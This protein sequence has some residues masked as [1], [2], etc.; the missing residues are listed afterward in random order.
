MIRN[1]VSKVVLREDLGRIEGEFTLVEAKRNERIVEG[2]D[3]YC[4]EGMRGTGINW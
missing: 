2:G 4:E 3:F 1:G